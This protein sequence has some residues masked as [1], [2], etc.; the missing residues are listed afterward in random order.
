MGVAQG[1]YE[2]GHI[3]YMR[4]DSPTLSTT[5]LEAAQEM[6]VSLF[7]E[8][9]LATAGAKSSGKS[10]PKNAQEAHEAIRPAKINENL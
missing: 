9:H 2:K 1:L 3:T 7:G 4:T 8:D 6:V 5:A 10:V